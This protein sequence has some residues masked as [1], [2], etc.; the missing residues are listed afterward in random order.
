MSETVKGILTT[1]TA[2]LLWGVVAV[3]WKLL[4]HIPSITVMSHRVI[5]SLV[6]V[7]IILFTQS[8]WQEVKMAFTSKRNLLT[9]MATALLIGTNWLVFIWAVNNNQLVEASLGYFINPLVNMLLGMILLK[10]RLGR[11]QFLS[12]GL[13]LVGV[14]MLTVQSDRLPWIALVL[15]FSFAFYGLLRKTGKINSLPGLTGELLVLMPFACLYLF[16]NG[17]GP[18][19][20]FGGNDLPDILLL[21]CGGIVTAIP[22]LL[23]AHGARRIQYITVGFLQYLAPSGQLLIGIFVYHE[24]FTSMHIMS[25]GFIWAALLVYSISAVSQF[26]RQKLRH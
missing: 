7:S 13:A 9:I 25:F 2:F 20:F 23:F 21:M 8:R 11:W 18:G 15:A 24:P 22:L 12:V 10:E 16:L 19:D 17:G 6:F 4:S 26:K 5:W 14:V 1:M 3:F